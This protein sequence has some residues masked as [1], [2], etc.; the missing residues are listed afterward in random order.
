ME[1][2]KKTRKKHKKHKF[3]IALPL[4]LDVSSTLFYE[5]NYSRIPKINSIVAFTHPS[6][7]S[8]YL[9]R[10]NRKGICP[11]PKLLMSIL[12]EESEKYKIDLGPEIKRMVSMGYTEKEAERELRKA[13]KYAFL[14]PPPLFEDD[15]GNPLSKDESDLFR[16]NMIAVELSYRYNRHPV[17]FS[18]ISSDLF[19]DKFRSGE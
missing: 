3:I 4:S 12:N 9:H 19:Y 5:V 1:K 15:N 8:Q 18:Q 7:V 17:D 14:V 11:K 2:N 6:A 10:L 13:G 16:I